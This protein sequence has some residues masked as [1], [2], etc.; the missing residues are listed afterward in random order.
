LLDAIEETKHT[1]Q[2]ELNVF[3][4]PVKHRLFIEG[5]TNIQNIRIYNLLGE[6]VYSESEIHTSNK[7][8]NVETL[9]SGIYILQIESESGFFQYKF[10]KH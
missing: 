5:K 8:I 1:V 6:L 10:V 7:Q 3:P 4:N 2:E 9:K